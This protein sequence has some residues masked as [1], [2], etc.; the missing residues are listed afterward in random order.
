MVGVWIVLALVLLA[1]GPVA[2][3]LVLRLRA[4]VSALREA[5]RAVA[6]A[7]SPALSRG[8]VSSVPAE[9]SLAALPAPAPAAPA[10]ASRRRDLESAFGGAWLTWLGVLALFF[11][12]AFF[13]ATD[14]RGAALS[15]A[16]QVLIGAL[17]GALFLIAGRWSAGR[18]QRFLGLGLLGGGIALLDLAAYAAYAFHHL[19]PG[20]VV[21]PFLFAVALLGA[22]LALREESF[23]IAALTLCGALVTPLFLRLEAD[24]A[25]VL[26]PYLV[27]VNVGAAVVATRRAWR[28]LPPIAFA[29]T[30]L[31]VVLWWAGRYDLD[32][33]AAAWSGTTALWLLFA[34]QA[35]VA[36]GVRLGVE[37]G[38]MTLANALAYATA[39]HR[40]L[41]PDLVVLR[42][43]AMGLLALVYV[44][45]ARFAAR[46][47]APPA[48]AALAEYAGIVLAAIAVP[49]QFDLAWVGLGWAALALALVHAGLALPSRA[50]RVLGLALFAAAAVRILVF[51]TRAALGSGA[52]LRPIANGDFV[53]GACVAAAVVVA[54]WMLH[55]HR[56]K[57]APGEA[58]WI[59]VLAVAG[60]ALLL[61][62]L[63]VEVWATFAAREAARAT[64]GA[65]RLAALLTLSLVWAVYAGAAVVTGLATRYRPLRLFGI[66]VLGL[67]VAKVFVFD[68][69]MLERGY[70]IASFVGVGLLLLAISV[71]YQRERRA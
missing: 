14:L 2:L 71:L 52:A 39:V 4:Q 25:R 54:A 63:S 66:V 7:G 45:G 69:Q 3:V 15:G 30:L 16:G 49:V 60:A 67:L 68:L 24:P 51:D 10:F 12:T 64:P 37:R 8:H 65:L 46:A 35:L 9:P 11:G 56:D 50:H 42:G 48:A 33:R 21:Y 27:A 20:I 26:F 58:G 22:A 55:R 53:V 44:A 43:V 61:W 6:T 29:G 1:S 31:L 47:G 36:R 28:P 5:Q 40:L 32:A 13:L 23:T 34:V 38:V 59:D 57:L 19:I 62:R 41:A 70:R 17:V 18:T